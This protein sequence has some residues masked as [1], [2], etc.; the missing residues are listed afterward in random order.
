MFKRYLEQRHIDLNGGISCLA[1][2]RGYLK[3]LKIVHQQIKRAV[4]RPP[5]SI[6]LLV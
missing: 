1:F 5:F 2:E 4:S 3:A 6:Y